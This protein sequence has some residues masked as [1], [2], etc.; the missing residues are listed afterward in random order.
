[1]HNILDGIAVG[2]IFAT[3]TKA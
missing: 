3:G 1:L 2:I